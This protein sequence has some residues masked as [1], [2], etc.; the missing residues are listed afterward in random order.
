MN[1]K[2][3]LLKSL[4]A[5]N[6]EKYLRE[7]LL[8]EMLKLEQQFANL[9]FGTSN[10]KYQMINIYNELLSKNAKAGY[11]ANN[12]LYKYRKL[13][14]EFS[15]EIR[16]YKYGKQGEMLAYNALGKMKSDHVVLRNI[17]LDDGENHT[18]IDLLVIKK[19]IVT[20]VEVKNT[21]KNA[22]ITSN[23][24]YLKIKGYNKSVDCDLGSKMNLRE[25]MIR[26][27]L[28]KNGFEKMAIK[29]VVVFTK[30]IQIHD[31]Y[32]GFE[33]CYLSNL[34]FTI[35]EFYSSEIQFI[36]EMENVANLIQ[37]ENT[38]SYNS[39]NINIKELK[40][41]FVEVLVKIEDSNRPFN[42]LVNKIKHFFNTSLK[43]NVYQGA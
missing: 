41:S 2:D 39:A 30:N 32:D 6:K 26:K 31:E 35:D 22:F 14:I 19:G 43:N 27:I 20:I 34:A 25:E 29:Q 18:E 16:G 11:P 4:D 10:D 37:K 3:K 42:K 33:T 8:P 38:Y 15:D 36:K 23:G 7:E 5:M 40:K 13:S 24:I 12:E 17:E 28:D 21:K 1:K 9:T